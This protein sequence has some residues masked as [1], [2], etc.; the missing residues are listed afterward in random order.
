MSQSE[1]L[2][3]VSGSAVVVIYLVFVV[4]EIAALW[5]VFEKAGEPGW[6]A[7]IPIYNA[8]V[9]L[10]LVGRPWWWLLLFLIPVIG[11]LCEIIV[12]NDLSKSFGRGGGF[13]VG[14]V[15]LAFVFVPI[16]GFGPACYVGPAAGRRS[17]S[18][19]PDFGYGSSS[20]VPG[21]SWN[22]R[23]GP[24]GQGYVPGGS[25]FDGFG[26][27]ETASVWESRGDTPQG[28]PPDWYADPTG[29]HQLRYWDG[30]AWTGHVSDNGAQSVDP[31]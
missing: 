5:R 16:L 29:G 28:A 31:V 27:G 13:T 25:G 8:Y 4:V 23:P 20:A 12:A 11:L 2:A 19:H 21:G 30:R 3:V 14:L 6:A 10:K 18:G 9:I 17:L 22:G 26:S 24:E 15:L 7:I 1:M